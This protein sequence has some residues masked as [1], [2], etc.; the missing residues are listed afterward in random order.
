MKKITTFLIF[1]SFILSIFSFSNVQAIE[2]DRPIVSVMGIVLQLI[3]GIQ[4]G[5][6]TILFIVQSICQFRKH[7]G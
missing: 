1:S 3:M 6:D 5:L 4:D 7:G 2:D